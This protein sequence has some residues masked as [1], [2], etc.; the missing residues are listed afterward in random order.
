VLNQ[1]DDE[2]LRIVTIDNPAVV[3]S[4]Q[5]LRSRMGKDAQV[6]QLLRA[7][8]DL[9]EPMGFVTFDECECGRG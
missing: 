1:A 5:T 8:D 7:I 4:R 3:A 9:A 2:M 6:V